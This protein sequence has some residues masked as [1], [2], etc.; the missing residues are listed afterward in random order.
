MWHHH[1]DSKEG[2]VRSSS[3]LCVTQQVDSCWSGLPKNRGSVE[4]LEI[5]PAV[6]QVEYLQLQGLTELKSSGASKNPASCLD[7]QN[8]FCRTAPWI[9]SRNIIYDWFKNLCRKTPS[10][11]QQTA[12]RV[13]F[14]TSTVV[15]KVT[16]AFN[17]RRSGRSGMLPASEVNILPSSGNKDFPVA[18]DVFVWP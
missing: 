11:P 17:G 12:G 4:P 8:G 1:F 7:S 10:K 3:A 9:E 18:E 6:S 13:F 16:R 14:C 2:L 15:P 5:S